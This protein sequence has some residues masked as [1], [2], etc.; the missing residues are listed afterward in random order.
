[1]T[2]RVAGLLWLLRSLTCLP[3]QAWAF[4]CF[5]SFSG[6][7]PLH[8]SQKEGG[9]SRW[10]WGPV[11]AFVQSASRSRYSFSRKPFIVTYWVKADLVASNKVGFNHLQTYELFLPLPKAL[12]GSWG[13]YL[14]FVWNTLHQLFSLDLKGHLWRWGE[15]WWSNKSGKFFLGGIT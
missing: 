11:D 8:W 10:L 9:G 12:P 15:Q 2:Q 14:W 1:M 5:L 6:W 4:C 13:H 7:W 3:D